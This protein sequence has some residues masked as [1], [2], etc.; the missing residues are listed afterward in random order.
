[1]FAHLLD[2][3]DLQSVALK[4]EDQSMEAGQLYRILALPVSFKGMAAKAWQLEQF[5][6]IM[7]LF[8]DVDALNV[9]ARYR[10]SIGFY[11]KIR[12]AIFSFQLPGSKSD[13]HKPSLKNRLYLMGKGN[14]L[15]LILSRN[16]LP[17]G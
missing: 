5:V 17:L 10:C 6:D 9:L 3:G 7:D 2:A 12:F 15:T 11:R 1:M 8:N 13:F 14:Y 16:Y 4:G